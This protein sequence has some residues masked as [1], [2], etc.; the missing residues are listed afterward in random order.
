MENVH[1]RI[2][3]DFI[4]KDD[5]DKFIKQQTKLSFNGIHKSFE[6]YD[7][8]TFKQNEVLTD[9]PIYLRFSVLELSRF[10]M[11]ETF[12]DKLHPYSGQEN[13]KLHYMDCDSLVLSIET[14]NI[15]DDL[16][17]LED[18]FD[19]S[20]LNEKYEL[21][22]KKNR[23][24]VGK[25][26]IETPESIWIGEFVAL[27]SKCYAFKCGDISKNKLKGIYKTYSKENKID[28]YKKCLDGEQYQQECDN[29]II[30]SI[31]HELYLQGVKKNYTISIR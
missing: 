29:F 3:V 18:L 19:F 28:E 7:S 1:N 11:F 21:L 12:Y 2:K 10:L 16:K 20:N 31:N 23:K 13:L 14:K 24:V 5:T 4:R 15:T 6:S 22:S 8:Y 25:F 27:R 17:N 9:K 30:R 26:K